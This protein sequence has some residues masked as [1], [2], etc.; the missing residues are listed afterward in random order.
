[1][2]MSEQ[3]NEL[4]S[5]LAL[6]QAEMKN[7]RL[8]KQNPHFKSRYAD[9]SEIRDTVT[10][11]LSKNGLAI[12]QGLDTTDD[13]KLLVVT[14]MLHKSGQWIESR[15]PISQDKPQAMGSAITYGRR[16]TLSAICNIAADE[17]D[18]A[19]AAH[20]R[21]AYQAPAAKAIIPAAVESIG[22][23][24]VRK[25]NEAATAEAFEEEVTKARAAWSRLGTADR[26]KVTNSIEARRAYWVQNSFPGATVEAAE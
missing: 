11:S 15:F 7:A 5:A 3:I 21:P 20:S 16:Y 24:I 9:L 12:T 2:R 6:A 25:F 4:A 10:P 14:R 23:T 1:M 22:D 13:G 19:E 26:A 18:D 17:D 8:N